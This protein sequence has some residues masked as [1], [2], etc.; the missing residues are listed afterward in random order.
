MQVEFPGSALKAAAEAAASA[1]RPERISL[2]GSQ[3]VAGQAA[4]L[5]FG[6]LLMDALKGV[7]HTQTVADRQQRAFTVGE[8]EATLESTMLSMQKAQIGFQS[9]L[10]VRNRLVQAY[11]EI[12][13]MP[14]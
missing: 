7:S 11:T 14:V 12:M 4:P 9:A 8:P 2:P 3:P 6:D 1:A 5:S 13:S 10:T